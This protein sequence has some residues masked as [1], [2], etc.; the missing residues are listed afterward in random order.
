M[1]EGNATSCDSQLF[2]RTF[3]SLKII[4]TPWYPVYLPSFKFR[5]TRLLHFSW[6]CHEWSAAA[7]LRLLRRGPTP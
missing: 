7:H 5:Y 6:E 1:C 2:Q 4:E 3:Y